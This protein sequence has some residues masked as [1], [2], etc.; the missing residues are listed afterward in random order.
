MFIQATKTI[1]YGIEGYSVEKK[2]NES[3]V[4]KV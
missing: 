4:K 2:Y 1:P 3:K